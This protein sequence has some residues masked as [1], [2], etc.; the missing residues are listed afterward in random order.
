[1]NLPNKL[2]IIRIILTFVFIYFISQEGLCYVAIAAAI[3]ILAAFLAFVR[4]HIVE[5]W[6]VILI[7]GREI[8][9]TSLRIFALS[10][11]KVLAAEKAGKQKTVSQMIA[12]FAILG[13]VLFKESLYHAEKWS[14]ALEIWWKCGIDILMLI[15]V[16]LTLISGVLYLWH[17]RRFIYASSFS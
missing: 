16:G 11:G 10:K 3:F 17:N 5:N 15:T 1:M 9:V 6:M 13:F 4:M 14:T 8:V 12:I 7:L 2:T